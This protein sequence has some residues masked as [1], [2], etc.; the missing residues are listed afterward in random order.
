MAEDQTNRDWVEV[1]GEAGNGTGVFLVGTKEDRTVMLA[2]NVT[3]HR[4]VEIANENSYRAF[5]W[6]PP[7]I[8]TYAQVQGSRCPVVNEPCETTCVGLACICDSEAKVCV[9]GASGSG[10]S[11][12]SEPQPALDYSL[13]LPI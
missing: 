12:E 10:S 8:A 1:Y 13:P 6:I 2:R 3:Y 11:E 9:D 4:C 7:A 5:K